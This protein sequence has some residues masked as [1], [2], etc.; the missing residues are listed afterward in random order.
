MNDLKMLDS[1]PRFQYI[2]TVDH[3]WTL[4]HWRSGHVNGATGHMSAVLDLRVS[5]GNDLSAEQLHMLLGEVQDAS[6]ELRQVIDELEL[7][8]R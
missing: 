3:E 5:L 1:T 7:L 2:E 4:H 6:N 8:G